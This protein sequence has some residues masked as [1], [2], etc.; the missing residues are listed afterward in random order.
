MTVFILI[1]VI[2]GL[3]MVLGLH[4]Y[5][6]V[7]SEIDVEASADEVW[8]ILT[9]FEDYPE[10]NP[11]IT[12]ISG[13][14]KEN[15]PIDVT[16]A[17]PFS[18]SLTVPLKIEQLVKGKEMIWSGK[19]LEP[20]ILDSLHTFHIEAVD[21]G[22]TKFTQKE[23]VGGLLLYPLLPFYKGMMERNFR[24]MNTALKNRAEGTVRV[25]EATHVPTGAA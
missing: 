20:K 1:A 18:K 6:E 5:D 19:L 13:E 9:N 7:N 2:V 12:S 4:T 3:F 25:S 8:K 15:S 23:R 16:I 22:R 21:S 14:L 24:K 17:L 11:F 10:W